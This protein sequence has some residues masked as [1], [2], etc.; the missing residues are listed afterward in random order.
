MT[1]AHHNT[2]TEQPPFDEWG[3]YDPEQAGLSAVLQR[4]KSRGPVAPTG[5]AVV[6]KRIG[7]QIIELSAP[8]HR[9]T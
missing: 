5:Q 8:P 7:R 3:V 1:F 2:N 4:V 9:V 6:I